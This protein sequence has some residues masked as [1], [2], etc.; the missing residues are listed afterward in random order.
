M[1][2]EWDRGRTDRDPFS[3][4]NKDGTQEFGHLLDYAETREREDAELD[5]LRSDPVIL[6][7]VS[8]RVKKSIGRTADIPIMCGTRTEG[9]SLAFGVV[10]GSVE[11]IVILNSYS[12]LNDDKLVQFRLTGEE[13]ANVPVQFPCVCDAPSPPPPTPGGE[14]TPARR[15]AWMAAMAKRHGSRRTRLWLYKAALAALASDTRRR[16]FVQLHT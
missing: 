8:K 14:P 9:R 6:A 4:G 12:A 5:R 3:W 11:L 1:S 2:W 10:N 15:I 7:M 16:P 13:T